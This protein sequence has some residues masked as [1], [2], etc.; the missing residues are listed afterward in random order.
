MRG[1]SVLAVVVAV[2][3]MMAAACSDVGGDG[4]IDGIEDDVVR[5]GL[6][7]IEQVPAL[8]CD[9]DVQTVVVALESYET[10]EGVPAPDQQALVDGGYLRTASVL[11]D[12]VDGAI[13]VQNPDCGPAVAGAPA[14]LTAPAIDVGEIVTSAAPLLTSTDEVLAAMSEA[15]I[16]A[17]GGVVCAT[18]IAAVSAAGQRF[19][20]REGRNPESLDDLAGDL[21]R[22]ITLWDLDAERQILVPADGSPCLDAFAQR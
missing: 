3:V 5:P 1:A 12:V 13:V 14:P 6:T 17:Y 16:A 8:A 19:V 9:A 10:L 4:A 20:T 21:D 2:V 7:A 15:D 11:V 18:E 22:E